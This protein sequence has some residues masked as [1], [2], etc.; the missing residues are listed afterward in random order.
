MSLEQLQDEAFTAS[1]ASKLLTSKKRICEEEINLAEAVSMN[2]MERSL[3]LM[4]I[5]QNGLS[6]IESTIA[7]KKLKKKT[8]IFPIKLGGDDQDQEIVAY[9]VLRYTI[10][11]STNDTQPNLSTSMVSNDITDDTEVS[12]T[13]PEVSDDE[14]DEEPFK[15]PRILGTT[16]R[17]EYKDNVN[18]PF[19]SPSQQEIFQKP[20][21]NEVENN[22]LQKTQNQSSNNLE[23]IT[24]TNGSTEKKI[25]TE[26][27]SIIV[28]SNTNNTIVENVQESTVSSEK[29]ENPLAK[30]ED[31]GSNF[32]L[33]DE[34]EEQEEPK[35][36]EQSPVM[37]MEMPTMTTTEEQKIDPSQPPSQEPQQEPEEIEV[38]E[39]VPEST[40]LPIEENVTE[41]VT[42]QQEEPE[43]PQITPSQVE[44]ESPKKDSMIVV[45]KEPEESQ[46]FLDL[47]DEE[48]EETKPEQINEPISV[49]TTQSISST[50]EEE[51]L[52]EEPGLDEKPLT[53]ETSE[54]QSEEE[55]DFDIILSPYEESNSTNDA[56]L[57]TNV[58]HKPEEQK[59]VE[60]TQ[61]IADI[62]TSDIVNKDSTEKLLT[63]EDHH[64]HSY[65]SDEDMFTP[66]YSSNNIYESKIPDVE[67]PTIPKPNNLHTK[68]IESV[69]NE[70]KANE[71]TE[72][73]T[74]SEYNEIQRDYSEALIVLDLQKQKIIELENYSNSF[75]PLVVSLIWGLICS[76]L[77]SV[78]QV[79][80][81]AIRPIL[82]A[83]FYTIVVYF[84]VQLTRAMKFYSYGTH[85]TNYL[86]EIRFLKKL[87]SMPKK[88]IGTLGN[89][90]K[91]YITSEDFRFLDDIFR[92]AS[93]GALFALVALIL[94]ALFSSGDE[95]PNLGDDSAIYRFFVS[96]ILYKCLY[97]SVTEELF[98]RLF[99]LLLSVF[100]F[101]EFNLTIKIKYII[102][103]YTNPKHSDQFRNLAD[104]EKQQP[105]PIKSGKAVLSLPHYSSVILATIISTIFSIGQ[106][107]RHTYTTDSFIFDKLLGSFVYSYMFVVQ[108]KVEL[109]MVAHFTKNLIDVIFSYY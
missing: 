44:V 41:T 81:S 14:E 95:Q 96:G 36:L 98:E 104:F 65:S 84:G 66:V 71:E 16:P 64:D 59:P 105:K 12:M 30:T 83:T 37:I 31:E 7:A 56:N 62:K 35:Q 22:S 33:L 17:S 91:K 100:I 72:S 10:S 77:Y 94:K 69:L 42:P 23:S 19:G 68:I 11:C 13:E 24:Q 4:E 82:V 63:P 51:P 5:T 80:V 46:S 79:E 28:E 58:V 50:V 107:A 75:H 9:L 57:A 102:D 39:Q 85:L 38:V 3:V 73:L 87:E 53:I 101:N 90:L 93:W 25:E 88:D 29:I 45:Q 18:T 20:V 103:K 43:K 27:P 97:R 1:P 26:Q 34:E 49:N 92:S 2:A 40:S 52:K 109:C 78:S 8:G 60:E 67:E 70:N 74:S 106:P 76:L 61:P 32:F 15:S 21:V 6:Q 89:Y 48:E 55:S 54:K 108:E 86:K 99:C 47:S